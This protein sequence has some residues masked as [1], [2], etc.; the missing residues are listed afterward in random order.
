LADNAVHQ[1]I[2]AFTSGCLDKE[3]FIQFMNYILEN[4]D[5]PKGEMGELQNIISLVPTLL[6]LDKPPD[7][8][9][10]NLFKRIT[11]DNS[12]ENDSR[13]KEIVEEKTTVH[14]ASEESY[15]KE[16]QPVD[17]KESTVP[18]SDIKKQTF[19]E[20]PISTGQKVTIKTTKIKQE[21]LHDIEDNEVPKTKVVD[22]GS[23]E[24]T[25]H[26][27]KSN[28]FPWI[29]SGI[30]LVVLVIVTIYFNSSKTQLNEEIASIK[31][32][33]SGFQ[34]EI[35]STNKFVNDHVELIEFF[36]HKN[37]EIVN[38]QGSDINLD[39]SGKL[40]ISFEA[41]EGLLQLKNTTPLSSDEAYQLWMVS[42]TQSYSLGMI[43]TRPDV[44]YYKVTNIPFLKKEEIRMFRITKE[45][46]EGAEIP[47]GI[48]YLFGVF[49]TEKVNSKGR[50]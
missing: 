1:I 11:D 16:A 12:S 21:P 46:R 44:E 41:G 3:N 49:S 23:F 20:D 22:S 39:A 13:K 14:Q 2:S 34:S 36:N 26:S 15:L 38:F 33:L 17:D 48:T 25:S 7:H 8:L 37:V 10:S 19:I 24:K 9:K 40:L 42:K 27:S 4:D 47:Q 45:T 5:L 6:E 32:R 35:A 28:I 18:I 43:I 30:L 31:S 50:R 29:L